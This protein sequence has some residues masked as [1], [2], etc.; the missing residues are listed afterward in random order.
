MKKV[1]FFYNS[2][3]DVLEEEINKFISIHNVLDIQYQ[4]VFVTSHINTKSVMI[5]YEED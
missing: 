5:V 2:Y 1:K 4:P 3:Y